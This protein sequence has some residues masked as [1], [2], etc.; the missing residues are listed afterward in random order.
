MSSEWISHRVIEIVPWGLH[1]DNLLL[2]ISSSV[3]DCT[4]LTL[5]SLR[6]RLWL[7]QIFHIIQTLKLLRKILVCNFLTWYILSVLSIWMCSG[8]LVFLRNL[9]NVGCRNCVSCL[10]SSTRSMGYFNFWIIDDEIVY[11]VV[12][13]NICHN[14]L[15]ITLFNFLSPR[16][17]GLLGLSLFLLSTR[18][19]ARWSFIWILVYY[20]GCTLISIVVNTSAWLFYFIL[21]RW[22]VIKV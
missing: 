21:T 6:L 18:L 2:V 1:I 15:P 11:V 3:H 22:L 12:C 4:T 19:F 8:I 13:Y 20:L 7:I 16:R 17:A 5:I 10:Q 9:N 14:F